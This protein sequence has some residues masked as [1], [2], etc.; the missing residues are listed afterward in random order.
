MAAP[1]KKDFAKKYLIYAEDDVDDREIL[2]E[3]M[4]EITDDIDVIALRDGREVLDF[5][6]AL[7]PTDLLPCF[8]LLDINMPGMDGYETLKQLKDDPSYQNIQ[9]IMYSTATQL[10]EEPRA[11]ALGA[12]RFITK[13]F[14]MDALAGIAREFAEYC[15]TTPARRKSPGEV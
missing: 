3:M 11:L 2:E 7:G 9:V 15:E 5:L 13:P 4:R 6:A 12:S 8:I 10:R 1:L 14:T